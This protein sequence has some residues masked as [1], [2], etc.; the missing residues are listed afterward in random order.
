MFDNCMDVEVTACLR[1]FQNLPFINLNV[2]FQ[3]YWF[4]NIP[5]SPSPC[6]IYVPW[7]LSIAIAEAS[8]HYKEVDIWPARMS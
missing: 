4:S 6:A 2:I 1:I 3:P 5:T 7:L 8:G